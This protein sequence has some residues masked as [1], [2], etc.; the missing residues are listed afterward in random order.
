MTEHPS[1]NEDEYFLR[2]DAELIADLKAK[3]VRRAEAS[4]DQRRARGILGVLL[5]GVRY[6]DVRR[7]SQHERLDVGDAAHI[8]WDRRRVAVLRAQDRIRDGE[9]LFARDD[10]RHVHH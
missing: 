2:Q 9:P 3:R 8:L 5:P 7:R 6:A 1:Q 10:Q 4:R